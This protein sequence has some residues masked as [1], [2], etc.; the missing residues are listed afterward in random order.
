[1]ADRTHYCLGYAFDP[2]LQQVA[3]LQKNRPAFLFGK[4]TGIGGHVEAG[5]GAQEAV[6]REF[7]EEAGVRL[8]VSSW[9]PVDHRES[10][11][12]VLDVYA[13]VCDLAQVRA[14]T[15]EPIQIFS[16]GQLPELAVL[17]PM[18]LEDLASS[19]RLLRAPSPSQTRRP[20]LG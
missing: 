18:V 2:S 12:W 7:E 20:R 9:V 19:Q 6:A 16:L 1:M 14:C 3:L 17:G 15:E 4:W 8:P 10:D 11:A 5:E 13:G